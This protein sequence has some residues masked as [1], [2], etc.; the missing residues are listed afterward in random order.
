MV[1]Q[2]PSMHEVLSSNSSTIKKKKSQNSRGYSGTQPVDQ[3]GE[4]NVT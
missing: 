2:R 3:E 4:V 1:E